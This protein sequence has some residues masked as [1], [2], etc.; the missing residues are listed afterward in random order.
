MHMD[1]KVTVIPLEYYLPLN[2]I[3]CYFQ[4]TQDQWETLVQV[5][6]GDMHGQSKAGLDSEV[7]NFSSDSFLVLFQYNGVSVVYCYITVHLITQR[8]KISIYYY[9]SQLCGLTG[10][11]GGSHVGSLKRLQSDACWGYSHPKAHLGWRA[12]VALSHGYQLRPAIEAQLGLQAGM[13]VFGYSMRF[14]FL[15][16]WCLVLR[17]SML[18]QALQELYKRPSGEAAKFL[19]TQS[20]KSQK[21]L[22]PYYIGQASY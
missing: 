13:A 10:L 18:G 9:I 4:N 19:M 15:I 3:I 7:W 1:Q 21:L 20:Q 5:W 16:A 2:F 6:P 12:R 11:T 17:G 22:P 14:K 8:L